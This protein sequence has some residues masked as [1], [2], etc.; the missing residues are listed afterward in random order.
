MADEM[1]GKNEK[2]GMYV[3]LELPVR[4]NCRR[5]GKKLDTSAVQLQTVIIE[6]RT[7][8]IYHSMSFRRI[9]KEGKRGKSG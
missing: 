9:N 8:L 3:S 5:K 4:S 7:D 1:L 2:I 6:A